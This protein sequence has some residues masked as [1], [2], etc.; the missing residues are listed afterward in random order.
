MGAKHFY[1]GDKK[2]YA[3]NKTKKASRTS[4]DDVLEAKLYKLV[5]IVVNGRD[6]E[7]YNAC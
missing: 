4:T 1:N 6:S 3:S 2:C 5:F 7:S